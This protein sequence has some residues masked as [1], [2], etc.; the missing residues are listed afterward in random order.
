MPVYKYRALTENGLKIDGVRNFNTKDEALAYLR[1]N[2]QFPINI[3]ELVEGGRTIN[4]VNIFSKVKTKDIAIFCRQFYT[5]INAGVIILNSLDILR[6]QTQNKILRHA[7]GE[8]YESVQKGMTLSE[9]MQVHHNIF[10]DLLINMVAAGEVSGTLDVVM[11]RMA[12]HYEKEHKINAKVTGAMIYPAFLGAIALGMIFFLLIFVLPTFQ[13]VFEQSGVVLP[14]PTRI[15]LGLSAFLN[16]YFLYIVLGCGLIGYF[17]VR[18]VKSDDGTLITDQLKLN[19]P[20]LKTLFIMI[21][22]SRFTRTLSTLLASGTPLIKALESVAGVIGNKVV[23]NALT[24]AIEDVKK[25]VSLSVPIR[26]MGIFPPMVYYMI[27]IG[28]E[29]GSLDEIMEKT[30]AYYDD[31]LES[32]IAAMLS[33]LEPLFILIMAVFVGGIVASIML[34]VFEMSSTMG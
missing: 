7:V 13:T 17:T 8:M 2:N 29:S 3:E 1:Q 21:Y 28:E 16:Q 25:G 9:A 26:N 30:A 22:T 10:P 23:K 33:L 6:H 27:S 31:E 34:P 14:L 12:T 4:V 11:S 19:T 32:T 5:M 20:I 18:Y 24:M 15:L